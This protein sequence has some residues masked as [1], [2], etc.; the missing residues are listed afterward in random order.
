MKKQNFYIVALGC[1]K[2]LVDS[3]I[4]SGCMA[5]S[6][7][8]ITFDPE[9]A[10]VYIINTCAFLPEAREEAFN[11][12]EIAREWRSAK[13]GRR[14]V[15]AGCIAGY[16]SKEVASKLSDIDLIIGVDDIEILAKKLANEPTPSVEKFTYL[17]TENTP[18]MQFTVPHIAYLK[19]ADGCNNCCSYCAIPKLRGSLR[20]RTL[21]SCVKEA[22]MLIAN[23]VKELV[24]IAQDITVFGHDRKDSGENLAKLLQAIEKIPGDFGIRLLYTHPAHYTDEL[25]DTIANSKKIIPYL[26][27]PLQHIS[28]RILSDMNRHIDTKGIKTLLEKLRNKIPNLSIRTTFITGLPGETEEEFNE[29]LEF[30]KK[31]KFER[32]GVFS[33]APEP[34]TKAAKMANQVPLEIANNRAKIIMDKQVA[35]MKRRNKNL[36]GSVEKVIIDSINE[37]GIAFARNQWDAPDIDN[38]ILIPE[39]GSSKPGLYKTV[40]IIDTYGCNIVGKLVPNCRR[41]EK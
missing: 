4:I 25:I 24:I 33:Y 37:D 27:M 23:G 8:N 18:R 36:I 21:D 34:G 29:L 39:P 32:L 11:E 17:A 26:D 6:N 12:I 14:I 40:E 15:V 1:P 19:I 7:W 35:R 9:E 30:T 3:E 20:S 16:K 28:D 38:V 31:F 13:A 22:A 5:V 2:N 10:D 41:K